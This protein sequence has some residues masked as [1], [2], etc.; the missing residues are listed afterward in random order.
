[1]WPLGLVESLKA[2]V[3]ADQPL[4]WPAPKLLPLHGLNICDDLNE[5]GP[6]RQLVELFEKD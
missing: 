5:N 2:M 4:H 3:E 6:N 1:M